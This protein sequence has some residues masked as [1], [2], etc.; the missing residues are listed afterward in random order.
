MI[1]KSSKPIP[2]SSLPLLHFCLS[3]ILPYWK[4][5]NHVYG[6]GLSKFI[7]LVPPMLIE[8]SNMSVVINYFCIEKRGD[9]WW[10]VCFSHHHESNAISLFLMFHY[11]QMPKST[12]GYYNVITITNKVIINIHCYFS[13]KF[14]N[15]NVLAF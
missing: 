10:P 8:T 4:G 14:V 7:I 5:Q 6:C 9:D 12:K 1:I 15:P 2:A 13:C 3:F 11:Q